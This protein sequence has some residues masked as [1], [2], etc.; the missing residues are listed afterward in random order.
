[1]LCRVGIER[2]GSTI[3]ESLAEYPADYES[4]R[5]VCRGIER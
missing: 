4:P 1:M 2:A 5:S 3:A